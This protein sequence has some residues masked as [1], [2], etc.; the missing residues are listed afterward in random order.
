MTDVIGNLVELVVASL[1][2]WA[3]VR[4]LVWCRRRWPRKP[5]RLAPSLIRLPNPGLQLGDHF[6]V[7]AV[8]SDGTV[9]GRVEIR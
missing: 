9:S 6:I 7:E 5:A 8:N 4:T 3:G 1:L 2:L